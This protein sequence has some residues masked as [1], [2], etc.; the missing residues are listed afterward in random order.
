MVYDSL[1]L[2]WLRLLEERAEIEDLPGI[3]GQAQVLKGRLALALQD[4][5]ILRDAIKKLY[6]IIEI[7]G[8][9][10]LDSELKSLLVKV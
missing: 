6:E 1:P 9:E 3:Y 5:S 10:F 2:P 4:D 8:V 7:P